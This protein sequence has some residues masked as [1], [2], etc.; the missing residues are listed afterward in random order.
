MCYKGRLL[1]NLIT[2]VREMN[3]THVISKTIETLRRAQATLRVFCNSVT[4]SFPAFRMSQDVLGK[5]PSSCHRMS[6][7]L[8]PV[9]LI[10]WE[11]GRRGADL[12]WSS[13]GLP[14]GLQ[15]VQ[16]VV[17]VLHR[18]ILLSSQTTS[19]SARLFLSSWSHP[20]HPR[21]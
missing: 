19:P 17:N 10:F 8:S 6:S 2:K 11:G 20:T 12:L 21:D 3:S 14:A 4:H 9:L 15:L 18:Q 1:Y 16:D 7:F 5:V 13:L